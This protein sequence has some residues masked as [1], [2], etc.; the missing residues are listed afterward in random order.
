MIALSVV[1]TVPAGRENDAV[2]HL[3]E[4]QKASRAEPGCVFYVVHQ[5]LDEKRRFFIYEMYANAAALDAH[6]A[7]EHFRRHALEGIRAIAETREA[8]SFVPLV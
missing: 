1:Y 8:E 7:S 5:G 2:T 4:L 6:R 3:R